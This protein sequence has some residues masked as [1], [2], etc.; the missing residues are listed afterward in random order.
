MKTVSVVYEVYDFD[1]LEEIAR[2]KAINSE[3]QFQLEM[4]DDNSPLDIKR[5]IDEAERMLT[6]WFAGGYIWDY[7]HDLII[8]NCRGYDYLSDGSIFFYPD[9]KE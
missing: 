6:P 8:D 7:A 4:A 9:G 1:E 5:A 2:T 3:I